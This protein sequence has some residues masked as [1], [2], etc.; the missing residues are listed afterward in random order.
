ML[1]LSPQADPLESWSEY[2]RE[3]FDR[4]LLQVGKRASRAVACCCPRGAAARTPFCQRQS[5][6]TAFLL[7]THA[8]Y[9]NG[10]LPPPLPQFDLIRSRFLPRKTT[11]EIIAYFYLWKTTHHYRHYR[12]LQSDGRDQTHR[13][14][15]VHAGPPGPTPRCAMEE[16]TDEDGSADGRPFPA[17][18][19]STKHKQ[20]ARTVRQ[21]ATTSSHDFT[22]HSTSF[23][24]RNRRRR[25]W[26][27]PLQPLRHRR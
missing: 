24:H 7:L 27:P 19:S 25:C 21:A 16:S 12:N 26:R 11:S 13:S 6:L 23:H 10:F 14:K 9:P 17:S 20:P 15:S 18:A 8:R 2:E 22:F 1:L 3:Q 4:G 5:N